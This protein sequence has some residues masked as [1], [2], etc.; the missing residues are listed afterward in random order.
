MGFVFS[1]GN[2]GKWEFIAKEEQGES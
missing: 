2:M 1:G